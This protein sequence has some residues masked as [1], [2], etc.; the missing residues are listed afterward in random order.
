MKTITAKTGLIVTFLLVC[1][2]VAYGITHKGGSR[3][4]FKGID[5][6]TEETRCNDARINVKGLTRHLLDFY[7]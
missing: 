5:T 1:V 2:L 7:R 6:S 4:F 3:S